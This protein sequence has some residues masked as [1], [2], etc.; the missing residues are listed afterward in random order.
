MFAVG[1]INRLLDGAVAEVLAAGR[2]D[3]VLLQTQRQSLS[4]RLCKAYGVLTWTPFLSY[5]CKRWH[6]GPLEES[7]HL[8][9]STQII[10]APEPIGL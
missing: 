8:I 6:G 9:S 1:Q 10:A 5:S 7:S 3:G 2:Q 4:R